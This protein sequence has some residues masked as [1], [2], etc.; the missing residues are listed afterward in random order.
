MTHDTHRPHPPARPHRRAPHPPPVVLSDQD[1]YETPTGLL[2]IAVWL[3]STETWRLH[4]NDGTPVYLLGLRG[5][6]RLAL[7]GIGL[8]VAPLELGELTRVE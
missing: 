2:L 6:Q 1:W 5:W 7:T 4:A 8:D 3:P